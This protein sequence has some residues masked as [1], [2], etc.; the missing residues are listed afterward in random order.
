MVKGYIYL[1]YLREFKNSNEPIYKIGKT[2]KSNLYR[3]KSYPKDSELLYYMCCEDCHNTENKLI[4]TFKNKFIQRDDIGTEY[5]EGDMKNMMREI[6]EVVMEET[7]ETEE[8]E[9]G[10]MSVYDYQ[11]KICDDKFESIFNSEYKSFND[12]KNTGY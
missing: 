7:E 8:T 4:K 12:F 2:T 9:K 5:F 3:F 10:V 1:I 6:F 11:K